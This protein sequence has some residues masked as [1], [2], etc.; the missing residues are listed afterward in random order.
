[1]QPPQKTVNESEDE[2]TSLLLHDSTEE[3]IDSIKYKLIN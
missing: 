2:R 3:G 1:M